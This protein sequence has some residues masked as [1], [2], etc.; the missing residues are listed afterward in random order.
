VRAGVRALGLDLVAARPSNALSAVHIPEHVGAD[1]VRETLARRFGI[2]VAGGQARLQGQIVRI[3]HLG[4][5]EPADILLFLS[6]FEAALSAHGH[7]VRPGTALAAAQPVL[8]AL[9][10]EGGK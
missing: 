2:R 4:A 3:G 8:A 1:A 6:A 10:T 5:H 7:P 9:G